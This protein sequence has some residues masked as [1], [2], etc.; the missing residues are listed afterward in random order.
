MFGLGVQEFIVLGCCALVPVGVGLTTLLIMRLSASKN[1][2]QTRRRRGEEH[3]KS[4][5]D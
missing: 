4:D 2:K 3:D 1:G 5:D